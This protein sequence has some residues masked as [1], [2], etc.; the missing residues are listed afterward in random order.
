MTGAM[1]PQWIAGARGCFF[2]LTP[3][4]S[5]PHL[6]RALLEGVSFA[7]R[8]IIERLVMLGI[9]PSRLTLLAGGSRSRISAQIR[10]DVSTLP[11][12]LHRCADTSVIGA[13]MLAGVVSHAFE[14]VAEA[15]SC[16]SPPREILDPIPSA[17]AALDDS[18]R[19]YQKLFQALKPVF[20]ARG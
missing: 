17:S 11:V 4:H 12:A 14:T 16:A 10:A 13:A 7:M 8:D 2:G 20:N 19:R 18:Y 9:N 6:A 3:A 15:A 1:T 5:T